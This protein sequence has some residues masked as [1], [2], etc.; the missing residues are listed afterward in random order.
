M[1]QSCTSKCSNLATSLECGQQNSCFFKE[2][3]CISKI[4]NC[5]TNSS[6]NITAETCLQINPNCIFNPS[7]PKCNLKQESLKQ[8]FQRGLSQKLCTSLDYCEFIKSGNFKCVFNTL[9]ECNPSQ[10]NTQYCDLSQECISI[11]QCQGL[12]QEKCQLNCLWD[13]ALKTCIDNCAN[14]ELSQCLTAS[15]CQ[16]KNYCVINQSKGNSV[17]NIIT[18]S[19][20][21]CVANNACEVFQEGVCQPKKDIC[22]VQSCPESICQKFTYTPSIP[23]ALIYPNY[24]DKITFNLEDFAKQNNCQYIQGNLQEL[25]KDKALIRLSSTEIKTIKFDYCVISTG[26]NYASQIKSDNQILNLEQRKEQIQQLVNKLKN[27]KKILIVGGG[28]VATEIAGILSQNYNNLQIQLWC[29][30]SELLSQYPENA[31]KLATQILV[32]QG[33]LIEYDKEVNSLPE[34]QFDYTFDCRGN[35]YAPDFMKSEFSEYLD[36]KGRILVDNYCRLKGQ[37]NI[38]CIGDA[39]I[40]PNNESKMG[41]NATIQGQFAADNITNI[42]N[43]SKSLKNSKMFWRKSFLGINQREINF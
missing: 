4:T 13:Q 9:Y 3:G 12:S 7:V 6:I 36:E 22:N 37:Q 25:Y 43:K 11:N 39:C 15:G 8:C 10:C 17:C 38:F 31:R 5:E 40:T 23:F 42:E 14:L 29:R 34:N 27:S 33:V 30:Q 32:K 18:S 21:D 24:L 41:Y 19:D 20:Q 16:V 35:I 1:S 28:F 26:S 2:I